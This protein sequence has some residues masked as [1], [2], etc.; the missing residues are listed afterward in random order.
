MTSTEQHRP[1]QADR[2]MERRHLWMIW[3]GASLAWLVAA[4]IGVAAVG[5]SNPLGTPTTTPTPLMR[6]HECSTIGDPD[7]YAACTGVA[8]MARQRRIVQQNATATRS[9]V[10]GTVI[11]AP[12]LVSLVL[13][14]WLSSRAAC[15]SPAGAGTG[16]HPG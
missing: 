7:G 4:T 11:M 6:P 1:H 8:A 2:A 14:A 3:A 12:P 5:S 9:V 13:V 15:R 10:V 16:S